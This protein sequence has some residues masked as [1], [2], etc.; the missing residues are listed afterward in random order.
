MKSLKSRFISVFASLFLLSQAYIAYGESGSGESAW[1]R[2]GLRSDGRA[3]PVRRS[4]A[5]DRAYRYL[6][7][8]NGLAVLL[9]SDPDTDKAAA[10]MNVQ[11]G[12]FDNPPEREGLAHFLEHMLFLGTDK[13]PEAG[14]Y[15]KFIIE[16]G[17]QHNAYTSMEN[18]NYFFDIEAGHLLAAL[19][20]FSRFFIAPRFDAQYVDRERNAVESEFRLKVKDDSR[21]EWEIFSEQVDPSHPLSRFSVGNLETLA[22]RK[23]RPVRT[24][25]IRFYEQYYSADRMSLVVLGAQ[26]LRQLEVVVRGLFADIPAANGKGDASGRVAPAGLSAPTFKHPLPFQLKV[27]PVKDMRSL[28]I[29][30]PMPSFKEQWR[31]RPDHFW[32]HLIG[33]ETGGSLIARLKEAGLANGLSA[34]QGF[35]TDRGAAFIVQIELTPEGVERSD[36]VLRKFFAW[37]NLARRQGIQNWRFEELAELLQTRFRFQE[38]APPASYVQFLS[39]KLR[40]YPPEEVVRGPYLLD[41]FDEDVL[42]RFADYL[43]PDN[44]FVSLMAPEVGAT[45]RVSKRYQAP[46]RLEAFSSATVTGLKQAKAADLAL[47][48]ANNFLAGAYPLSGKGGE[49]SQPLKLDNNQGLTIWHYQD[50]IFGS[51]KGVFDTRVTT[52]VMETC[53]GVARSEL[54]L[55]LVRDSLGETTYQA[56]LAGLGYSLYRWHGG[57]GLSIDGYT[58]RQGVLLEQ[59]LEAVITPQWLEND[60]QRLRSTLVRDFRNVRKQWPVRQLFQQMDPLLRGT[61]DKP[62][63]ANA[64]EEMDFA[65]M[66]EFP[67]SLFSTAHVRFY[68][69]GALTEQQVLEMAELTQAHLQVGRVGDAVSREEI[70]ALPRKTSLQHSIDVEHTD[71][72]VLLYVQGH[73][74]S[75]EERALVA[76]INGVLEAPFYTTMRTEKQFGYVVGTNI[77]HMNRVPGLTFYIQSPVAKEARLQGE[78]NGFIASYESVLG[79]MSKAELARIKAALLAN[80]KERPRNIN[81]QVGRHQ[82]SLSLGYEDFDF[83]EKLAEQVKRI[84]R[85]DLLSAYRRLLRKDSRRLWITTGRVMNPEAVLSHGQLRES[86][87]KVYAYPQ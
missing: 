6:T 17:G 71:S 79:D 21:R 66:R 27:K 46:Y 64:L 81:E 56:S 32:G 16:H 49:S 20:R 18:T 36:Q 12:S 65:D 55:A 29:V 85:D 23:G 42:G 51:P 68:G 1:W 57:I 61:C 67:A 44:A 7:L 84:G 48:P 33:D 54:Y 70:L 13:Y 87:E 80:I 41:Q 28:S 73:E 22:D 43:T 78:I 58:D 14:A 5:D 74:D 2:E 9:I 40:D 83:R 24:E 15:Q 34:G 60:F 82:E 45:D 76:T 19:N 59:V 75:L 30:F 4:P 72:G 3:H 26:T 38:K 47:A 63:L 86:A 10:S 25:L 37:L 8:D 53:E 69:G 50:Q 35:D 31:T 11:V 52:P 62:T 77:R 39:A